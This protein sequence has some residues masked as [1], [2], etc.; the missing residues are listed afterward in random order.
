MVSSSNSKKDLSYL[1]DLPG[2]S[3]KLQIFNADLVLPESFDKAIQGCIRVFHVAHPIDFEDKEPEE[4]KTQRAINANLGILK[5]CFKSKTIKRVIYTSSAFTIMFNEKGLDVL[6]ESHWSDAALE[7]AEKHGLDRITVIPT[8]IN[9]P[10]IC[11]CV[12][13]S[14]NV[15]MVMMHVD[16]TIDKMFEFLSAKY[17]VCPIPTPDSFKEIECTSRSNLSSKKVLDTRFKYK[18]GLKE[19]YNGAI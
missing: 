14:V 15:A 3:E 19:M 8:I 12:P 7:F 17:P 6:D 2:A 1:T 11:P 16:L 4:V 13:S 9:G 10:F 18:Y 5:A